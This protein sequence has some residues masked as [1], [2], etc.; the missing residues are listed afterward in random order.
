MKGKVLK[1][2][3]DFS[4]YLLSAEKVAIVPGIAFGADAHA[5]LAFAMSL[6]KIEEGTHR[7]KEAVSKL[8]H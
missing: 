1:G 5:R 7:I 8:H 2:S 6:E 3:L 4:D